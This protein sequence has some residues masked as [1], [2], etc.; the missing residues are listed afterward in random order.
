VGLP[1]SAIFFQMADLEES[2]TRP[3][4]DLLATLRRRAWWVA[5]LTVFAVGAAAAYAYT[6]P[7]TYRSTMKIVVG[8]GEGIFLPEAGNVAEQFTQTMSDLLESEIVAQRVISDLDLAIGSKELHDNLHISSKP[9]TA[10]LEVSYDDT[11]AERGRA[12]LDRIGAVFTALVDERLAPRTG[13]GFL[14]DRGNLAVTANV[15]DSAHVEEDP[16]APRPLQTM[17]A[18]GILG[19]LLGLFAAFAREQLDDTIRSVEQAELSFGQTSTATL[20]QS[21]LGYLPF[22]SSKENKKRLDP[23]LAELAVQRFRAGILWSWASK[24]AQTLLLT[25]AHPEEGKTTAATNLAVS[26]ARE[27]YDVIIVDADLRRP[28]VSSFLNCDV[29]HSVKGLDALVR[30]EA[31]V[32]DA[33]VEI[34]IGEPT[35]VPGDQSPERRGRLRALLATPGMTNPTE[36]DLDRTAGLVEEFKQH[37]QY[38]IFDAPPVLVVTDAYP[39]VASVDSVIALVRNGRST[40]AA[41]EQ[42]SRTLGRLRVRSVRRAELVVTEAEGA[43]QA[44]YPIE[45]PAEPR[46]EPPPPPP[47]EGIE[48]AEPAAEEPPVPSEPTSPDE[49]EREQEPSGHPAMSGSPP[50]GGVEGH[51]DGDR[52]VDLTDEESDSEVERSYR[53]EG[54]A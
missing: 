26:M 32:E 28:L 45:E 25:S 50:W 19:L 1:L 54:W 4:P 6:Q 27:G 18:A 31:S 30:G 20:P 16:V 8:Q 35:R 44:Y 24:D 17:G 15:F 34:P 46:K 5:A 12:V 10:V 7:T 48:E 14:G 38:V 9:S 42:F 22:G 36:F 39:L 29:S 49:E 53:S 52:V 41:T 3:L 47:V 13:S 43:K 33:L 21:F 37:A 51:D 23:V 2:G 40:M 11:N